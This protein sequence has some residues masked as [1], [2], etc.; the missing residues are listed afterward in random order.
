MQIHIAAAALMRADGSTLL[1]RKR[2]TTAFMQPGGKIDL[3]EAPL[4]ALYRELAEELALRPDGAGAAFIGRFEAPAA[5]EDE[6]TVIAEL[7]RLE[8]SAELHAQSEIEE[9]RWILPPDRTALE[10]A[11]LTRDVVLPAIW[12]AMEEGPRA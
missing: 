10:L 1:V 5:H 8:T 7:Y 12:G 6:A 9:I 3:G 4:V 2:G 11:P